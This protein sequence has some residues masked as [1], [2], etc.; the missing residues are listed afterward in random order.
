MP[1]HCCD[2]ETDACRTQAH[3]AEDACCSGGVPVF[4]TRRSETPA[5]ATFSPDLLQPAAIAQAIARYQATPDQSCDVTV[6]MSHGRF[7]PVAR[8]D[9]AGT[10][11]FTDMAGRDMTSLVG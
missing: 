11:R 7:A 3:K 6:D 4:E 10:V 9:C 2:H 8:Y 5:V 1:D